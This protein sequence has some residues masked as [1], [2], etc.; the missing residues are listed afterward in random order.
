MQRHTKSY[1]ILFIRQ[2][3]NLK[4][5]YIFIKYQIGEVLRLISKQAF[6][7]NEKINS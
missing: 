7:I 4:D 5:Y 1:Q 6:Q 3:H 2:T